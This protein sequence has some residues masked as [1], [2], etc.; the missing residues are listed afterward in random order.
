MPRRSL[1][2]SSFMSRKALGIAALAVCA[3]LSSSSLFAGGRIENLYAWVEGVNMDREDEAYN[4]KP[5]EAIDVEVGEE[6]QITLWGE[7]GG[8][9]DEQVGAS[10]SVAAGR[11]KIVI[12][13]SGNG[14]VRVRVKGGSG[15][16]AQLGYE[17]NGNYNMPGGLK[18]GR[19]S[20]EI[21]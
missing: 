9:E 13:G 20:F 7:N 5:S 4:I 8:E 10:F 19:I 2:G 11:D 14:W 15:G 6:V 17:V 18:W 1:E 16:V 3:I 21:E 12:T